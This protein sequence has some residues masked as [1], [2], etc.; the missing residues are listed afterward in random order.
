M[1]SFT[2]SRP[3]WSASSTARASSRSSSS[4]VRSPHGSSSTVSSQARIQPCSMF[5]SGVR[6][7]RPISLRSG[8]HHV[9]G[10]AG[11]LERV[12]ARA[13]VVGRLASSSSSPS[14]LRMAVHLLAQEELALLLLQPVAARRC[15]S[16]RPAR[17]RPGPPWP[18]RARGAP[19]RSTSIVSSS[20]TLRSTERS[21][22]Q[23]TMSARP[24][25]SSASTPRRMPRHLAAAEVLEQRHAA[26]P[27]A[28]RRAPWPRRW[29]GASSTGSAVHPQ[30]GARCRRRR[31]RAA[32]GRWPARRGR[33]CRRAGR[34]WTRR[35]R[36]RR[37]G[38]SGRRPGDEEQLA[39][40][41]R[42]RL[43]AALASSD[44]AAMVT[45]M[46]GSTTPSG[47]GRAGR[48]LGS[49]ATGTRGL[50][51]YL[52]CASHNLLTGKPHPHPFSARAPR[53][54]WDNRGLSGPG[55]AGSRPTE[56]P[57]SGGC[58][59]GWPRRCPG[60]RRRRPRS[61]PWP[62]P[63]L[64]A[65][66]SW[67]IARTVSGERQPGA[68]AAVGPGGGAGVGPGVGPHGP[69]AQRRG[70]AR[71]AG[72]R[73]PSATHSSPQRR[74][75]WRCSSRLTLAVAEL[76]LR[77]PPCGSEA[78]AGQRA[79]RALRRRRDARG[80]PAGT[81]PWTRWIGAV[82]GV[83]VSLVLPASR[84]VD[85]RQTLDRLGG[86]S[87]GDV[88][89]AMGSGLAE[90]WTSEQTRE[91]RRTARTARE[92]LVD[93]AVEA[94]GNGRDRRAGTCT[95]AA[96]SRSWAATRRV[97]PR[98]ER[99]A[100]GTWVIARSLDDQARSVRDRP[101]WRSPRWVRSWPRSA[102]ASPR[103]RARRGRRTRAA[104]TSAPALA[105]V[106]VRRARCVRGAIAPGSARPSSRRPTVR[107][108]R[109]RANGSATP[110][111]LVQVDRIGERPE[112]RAARRRPWTL[113]PSHDRTVREALE[114]R[115]RRR[116]PAGTRGI[117]RGHR[118]AA[119]GRGRARRRLRPERTRRPARRHHVLRR[120]MS[121][122]PSRWTPSS[123]RSVARASVASTSSST[124]P[125]GRPTST[126]RRPSPRLTTS[127]LALNLAAPFFVG[128]AANRVMQAQ[129]DGRGDRE[130][131]VGER[132]PALARRGRRTGRPRPACGT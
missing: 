41:R 131:R 130:H 111:A 56:R 52:R 31:R 18:S 37:P 119:G 49:M 122:T 71:R 51:E 8:P 29:P 14:S 66:L 120:P 12:D 46:P 50:Q 11:R 7:K 97:L 34:R 77:L 104:P 109:G 40:G 64:A 82:V 98:L 60:P 17:A 68:A 4:A 13:V 6:S 93:Q 91:W 117:G 114:G 121:G 10:H 30:A 65:G 106:R 61:A 100:I 22:H 123:T 102:A 113:G 74:S 53:A 54:R 86:G 110:P 78:G 1:R 36:R 99:T 72:W 26:W 38:R 126:R 92:R 88:L 89:E 128:Q 21:G 116:R 47:R 45:T 75:P 90:P 25:G 70:G 39:A 129:D 79:D 5:C 23:P 73:W 42:R 103:R 35:W 27:A 63:A 96:I 115:V 33:R 84:L 85:S 83:I 76:V 125:A 80:A 127:I 55:G 87:L 62:S 24:P 67:A 107:L 124:T 101:P 59:P 69:R 32:P 43:A 15:G 19:A 3:V 81:G 28:R 118:R 95:T 58:G 112:P 44:S 105:E 57:D 94:V 132:L 2:S 9:V 108:T 20:S 16:S 48:V